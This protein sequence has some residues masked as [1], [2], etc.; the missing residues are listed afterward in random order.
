MKIKLHIPTEQFGFCEIEVD[1]VSPESVQE[2]YRQYSSAFK[3]KDGVSEKE[4]SQFIDRQLEGKNGSED[5]PLYESMS[6]DQKRVV[7]II[8]RAKKRA[9]K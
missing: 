7:Q 6:D 4:F 5:I 3:A 9:A 2:T 1:E 8:K